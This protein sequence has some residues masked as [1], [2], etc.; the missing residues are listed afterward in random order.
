[1]IVSLQWL[2]EYVHIS[3]S[4]RE[5]AHK[6]TMSGIAVERVE[7]LTGDFTLELDLTPNRGDCLGLINLAR[8]VAALHGTNIK[9]PL[10][11]LKENDERIEE[12]IN[13]EIY[14]PDLCPRYAARLIK[15]VQIKPSPDW[16][17]ERL[18]K[19]GVRPINNVV[20]IT[21]YVM[22]E[23]NQPLHAFDYDLLGEQKT[24]I[25]RRATPME[26]ITTLDD[27]ERT[28]DDNDLLISEESRPLALA[29]IMG[30]KETEIH[31]NTRNVLL[32]SAH[33]FSRGIRKT[34]KRLNLRSNSSTRFEKGV[35]PE[36]VVF[37]INRAASLMAQW[38]DGEIVGAVLDVHPNPMPPR[39][40]NVNPD[41]VNKLLGCSL[42]PAE[43]K[44]ILN[45]LHFSVENEGN[46]LL[47]DIPGYRPDLLQEVDLIEEIARIYGY[48]NIPAQLPV[49]DPGQGGRSSYQKFKDEVLTLASR[50]FMETIN[51][52]FVSP[53]HFDMLTLFPHNS[54]RRALKIA[55]PMSEEQSVMRTL[56][57]PGL[58]EVIS[59]NLA[60]KNNDLAF[61]EMG[62]VYI[63]QEDGLPREKLKLGA[64]VTGNTG[65]NWLKKQ[66]DMDFYYLKG[67]LED[68]LQRLGVKEYSFIEGQE[69]FYHPGRSAYIKMEEE[70]IGHMGEIHPRVAQ[71]FELKQRTCALELELDKLY[72]CWEQKKEIMPISK[73]PGMERDLAV[74]VQEQV[75]SSLLIKVIKDAGGLLLTNIEVF[76]VYAGEQVPEGYKSIA[77]R[78]AFLSHEKTLSD[79]EV[80]QYMHQIID[81]LSRA[82]NA[83]LR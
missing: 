73:F 49:L 16:M 3:C 6:L 43:M 74:V 42:Y 61:F 55:N 72:P 82:L 1:M 15:N 52:S 66:I 80:N 24:I 44:A 18:I 75:S 8:E 29:G 38:A 31:E 25:V 32:E 51:Y 58:M 17:Q 22:L 34:A 35:D 71:H 50:N 33:F 60:R 19:A 41:Q 28:L 5:L 47:V 56:L 40:I 62:M 78:L 65:I 26:T 2:K 76:D 37:A 36:G 30:G 13:I 21:N 63:P 81:H 54:C 70:I 27:Q 45:R 9:L 53:R 12:Y 46:T 79:E 39:T 64:A 48:D 77:L 83:Q 68:L 4:A 7:T 67:I 57:I 69:E 59:R 10:I 14:D 23:T 20:D 11:E